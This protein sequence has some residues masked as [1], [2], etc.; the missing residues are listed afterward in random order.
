MSDP[1][2]LLAG[3]NREARLRMEE[4]AQSQLGLI[5]RAQ[6]LDA[7]MSRSAHTRLLQVGELIRVRRNVYRLRG[8]PPV[9]I[10]QSLRAVC[11][12]LGD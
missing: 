11:M 5:S 9:S 8:G 4:T 3:V 12:T 7:G 1:H 2:G 6:V 10:H